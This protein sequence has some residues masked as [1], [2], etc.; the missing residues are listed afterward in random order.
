MTLTLTVD[1]TDAYRGY[2]A[3][4]VTGAADGP[5]LLTRTDANGTNIVRQYDGAQAAGGVLDVTDAEWSWIGPWTD[6]HGVPQSPFYAATDAAGA[7]AT[8]P[9]PDPMDVPD[10]PVITAVQY[11]TIAV[12]RWVAA[13]SPWIPPPVITDYG[14]E[15]DSLST[16]HQIVGRRDPVVILDQLRTRTGS[17]T[18]WCA[19]HQQAAWVRDALS[20]PYTYLLRQ[21]DHLGM[22]M[23]FT[24]ASVSLAPLDRAY[25]GAGSAPRRWALTV[26]YTEVRNDPALTLLGATTWTWDDVAYTYDSWASV[27]DAYDSWADVIV[28]PA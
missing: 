7:T 27:R 10:T 2:L 5:V 17:F 12:S 19:H 20:G 23:Y 25:L 15:T 28:G 3:L 26:T 8:A 18:V 13:G 1:D 16:V 24:V 11:P 4:S 22:D 21:G 6:T 14:A 9:F